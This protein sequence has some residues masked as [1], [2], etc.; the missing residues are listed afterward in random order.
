MA[1]GVFF[2]ARAAPLEQPHVAAVNGDGRAA[3]PCI[4]LPAPSLW[5]CLKVQL[6]NL[7]RPTGEVKSE[8]RSVMNVITSKILPV[9]LCKM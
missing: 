6:V 9:K 1:S 4:G 8:G 3:V 2:R 5:F 7:R